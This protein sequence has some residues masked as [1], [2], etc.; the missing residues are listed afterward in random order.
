MIASKR[1]TM[2]PLELFEEEQAELLF[3]HNHQKRENEIVMYNILKKKYDV[4]IFGI[5]KSKSLSLGRYSPAYV[6]NTL[7]KAP[8][9][10]AIS[11]IS[12]KYIQSMP[13]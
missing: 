3:Y 12:A 8:N 11:P 4:I 13:A 10:T 6:I 5:D 9:S 1:F 7:P 2:I